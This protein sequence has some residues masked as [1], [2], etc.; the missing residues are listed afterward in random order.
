MNS[1]NNFTISLDAPQLWGVYFQ[2]SA[3]HLIVALIL[4]SI[5]ILIIGIFMLIMAIP[6]FFTTGPLWADDPIVEAFIRELE[7]DLAEYK[8]E[9]ARIQAWIRRLL[10]EAIVDEAALAE[11]YNQLTDCEAYITELVLQLKR[12]HSDKARFK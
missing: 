4:V 2:D 12:V 5:S 8:A 9:K 3:S 10:S 6:K 1:F 11:A 7:G